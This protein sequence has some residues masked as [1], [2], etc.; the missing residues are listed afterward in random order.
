MYSHLLFPAVNKK[1]TREEK[2]ASLR[3]VSTEHLATQ[4]HPTFSSAD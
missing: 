1:M 2:V 3:H 4:P